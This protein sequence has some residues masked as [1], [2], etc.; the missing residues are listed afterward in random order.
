MTHI[1][2]EELYWAADFYRGRESLVF[3]GI[4]YRYE[5]LDERSTRLAQLLL[6]LGCRKEDRVAVLLNN[7]VESLDCFFGAQKAGSAYVALNALHSLA[8]QRDIIRDCQ[9][10]VVVAGPEFREIVESLADDFREIR[11]LGVGWSSQDI[12]SYENGMSQASSERPNVVVD[13]NDITR[14]HY[15]SG[16]TGKPKGIVF[17]H[18]TSRERLFSFLATYEPRLNTKDTMLHVGP[19]THAAGNYLTPCYLRG[20]RNIVLG[21]FDLEALMDA[22]GT[23]HVSHLFLVPTMMT[24]FVQMAE[25]GEH[26]LSSLKVINYGVA[27]TPVDTLIR[28]I[29]TLGPIFRQHYGMS[30]CPQPIT[31]F[32][33]EEHDIETEKGRKRLTSCGKPVFNVNLVLRDAGGEP[34]PQGEIGEIT[35]KAEK[36]V[37]ADFWRRP[38]L[39]KAAVRDGWFYSGDLGRFDEEGFLYIVGR[40]KDM[41]ITGGFNVYSREVED[42]LN[43]HPDVQEAA[44]FGVEDAE[45]GEIVVAAVVLDANAGQI[46]ELD[47]IGFCKTRIASYKKPKILYFVED[48]PRNHAGKLAKLVVRD[49]FLETRAKVDADKKGKG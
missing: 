49:R 25:Q 41:I 36:Q 22:I 23:Y 35:L 20:T 34:V 13:P 32:P 16:T 2:G 47:L 19:L 7:C 37:K 48:L 3:D 9:P 17:R 8:E 6:S 40:N 1:A 31:V 11:F 27:P 38:D 10:R 43:M 12:D 30:E 21:R 15:T 24:R 4:R 39:Q 26:D 29:Q 46:T 42:A 45:W 33:R 44:V 5:D 14:I 18:H 28:G